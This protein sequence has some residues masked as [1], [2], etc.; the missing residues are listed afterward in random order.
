MTLAALHV[1]DTGG[2]D[3][4]C[5]HG[6]KCCEGASIKP[7]S[8]DNPSN[9][10]NASIPRSKT[11]HWNPELRCLVAF[12]KPT[13]R[14]DKE[15]CKDAYTWMQVKE[16]I[17]HLYPSMPKDDLDTYCAELGEAE[18]E[19]LSKGKFDA[20]MI[21][22]KMRCAWAEKEEQIRNEERVTVQWPSV[23]DRLVQ[24]NPTAQSLQNI[25]FPSLPSGVSARAKD[26]EVKS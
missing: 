24:L 5:C 12:E 8:P 20:L 13:T 3:V 26:I 4:H 15:K 7:G 2:G 9:S 14:S 10:D 17:Q 1:V 19:R 22:V 16:V 21:F 23:S 11:L 25:A 18:G 6:W